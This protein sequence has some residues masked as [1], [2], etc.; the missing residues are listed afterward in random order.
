MKRTAKRTVTLLLLLHCTAEVSFAQTILDSYC[1]QGLESNLHIQKLT[2][3]YQGA[4]WAL[5]ESKKL[6]GPNVDFSAGYTRN[7]RQPMDLNDGNSGG[8]GGLAEFLSNLQISSIRDG[9]FYYPNINQYSSAL[10]LTQNLYNRQL[11]YNKRLKEEN[12]KSS[13]SQL[14]DFKIELDAQIRDA[15]FQY[16]QAT[17]LKMATDRGVAIGK[18]NL[19]GIEI[20]IK[21]QK[22]TKDALYRAR[23]NVSSLETQ[24]RN[25]ENDRRKAQYYFNFLL[26]RAPEDPIQSDSTY[27]FST[28]RRYS[29]NG[30][31]DTTQ[32]GYHTDFLKQSANAAGLQQQYI[33]S[34]AGPIFQF[35]GTAGLSGSNL[36]FDNGRLPYGMLELSLKWNVFNSGVNK[37][38]AKQAYFQQ[39]SLL[40]QY[41][42]SR[43]Q[44]QLNEF[45]GFSDITTHL[46]NYES[47]LADYR[48]A[49]VYYRAI[50][51]KFG[52][53][54]SSLLELLDAENGLLEA[55][56]NRLKW[57]YALLS[58]LTVYQKDTGKKLKLN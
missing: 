6:F 41:E 55:D 9:K 18:E 26:N 36:S 38:K 37:A 58:K 42:N 3:D 21:Q 57:Y 8:A 4:I 10:Q 24:S 50:H 48:N 15:Y 20:L 23:A 11:A 35:R 30:L 31:R 12:S 44:Q 52:I 27:L 19:Q 14:E 34:Q 2:D 33:R 39:Q 49:E 16:M 29:V 51:T 17:A 22:Q 47:V 13:A 43:K 46:D 32:T 25:M 56:M 28:E 7:I 45:S 1:E 54:L 5:Q 53:G 40:R